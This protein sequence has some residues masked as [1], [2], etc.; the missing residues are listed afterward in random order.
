MQTVR[1]SLFWSLNTLTKPCAGGLHSVPSPPGELCASGAPRD[2]LN[3][4]TKRHSEPDSDPEFTAGTIIYADDSPRKNRRSKSGA[5]PQSRQ[6]KR[7]RRR[8]IWDDSPAN[9]QRSTGSAK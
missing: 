1:M 9:V 5:R 3:R 7:T 6:V 4:Q 8:E 2:F